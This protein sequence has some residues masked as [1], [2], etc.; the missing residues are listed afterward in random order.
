MAISGK[1]VKNKVSKFQ[2]FRVSKTIH[3][4]DSAAFAVFIETLKL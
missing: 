1:A 3:D 4:W 2:G